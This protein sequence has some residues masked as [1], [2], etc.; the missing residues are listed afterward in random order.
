MRD[1]WK[2]GTIFL[3][4]AFDSAPAGEAAQAVPPPPPPPGSWVTIPE[5]KPLQPEERGKGYKV[6]ATQW[7][8]DAILWGYQGEMTDGAGFAFGGIHQLNEDGIAHTRLKEG[9]AWKEIHE[10]LK[11]KNPL[12]NYYE[13]TT[14][15][16][17]ACKDLIAQGRHQY[18]EGR[19]RADEAAWVKSTLD[20]ALARLGAGMVTHGKGLAGAKT[21]DA[22]DKEQLATAGKHLE[23][24]LGKIKPLGG[25]VTPEAL[26]T[27]R[28]GQLD[29]ELAAEALGAEPPP[30]SLSIP[31]YDAGLK[32]FAIFG[33]D[34]FDYQTND[35]WV[36][37]PA[38]RRWFQKHPPAAPEARADHQLE[39]LG[40]GEFAM[41]G[42]YSFQP[43][44]R[45][46][47]TGP[48]R[49]IYDLKKNEWRADGHSEKPVTE[50]RSPQADPPSSP[51][52]FL[53]GARPDAAAHEAALKALPVNE[54][55]GLKPLVPL[56]GRDWATWVFDPQRDMYYVYG[57]GHASYPG[58]DVARYHLSTNRWEITD[59]V[60]VPIGC[61]GTNEMYP[62]GFNYN[63]RPW[64]RNHVWNGQ[65]YDPELKRMILGS[66]TNPKIDPYFYIYNPDKSDWDG[67]K[68]FPADLNNN[69]YAI[70]LRPTRHGMF[71]WSGD[72]AWLLD[73]KTSAWKKISQQGKLVG[74][75]VDGCGL[76]YDSKRDRMLLFTLGGYA[77]PYNGNVCV[78]DFAANSATL[79][80]PEAPAVTR[81][82][83]FLREPVYVPECDMML[84]ASTIQFD[85]KCVPDRMPAFD[86]A[87]NR[88]V[89]IKIKMPPERKQG[90]GNVC[91]SIAVDAKRGLVWVGNAAWDGNVYA[92]KLDT[93][94][95]EVKPLKDLVSE[96]TIAERH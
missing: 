95:T 44:G 19:P 9:G 2:L 36:F 52:S 1:S 70:Q 35:L 80:T 15:L 20:P 55:T 84:F 14:A 83:P 75:G 40:N 90:L 8:Q 65:A 91:T 85:K 5:R 61:S 6:P 82:D 47:H 4:L 62:G 21:T 11:Q 27:L 96:A 72:A 92:L 66:A 45:Y 38:K 81:W 86:C 46:S 31:A 23:R 3:V 33:G 58:V 17:N 76:G 7:K 25:L 28:A 18:F 24:A 78:V 93:S 59:P 88:W 77:K 13:A 29:L 43:K 39:S 64:C 94:K 68:R 32:V 48:A 22:Y 73:A 63:G 57:G 56:G 30:R 10:E 79:L 34:H 42:G 51:E 41:V 60:E 74:T 67:R 37:D 26:A 69:G 12:Q 49:W 89:G 87:N 50:P 54:L 16:R 53:K 71:A